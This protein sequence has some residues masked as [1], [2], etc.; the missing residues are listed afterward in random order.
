LKLE[1]NLEIKKK[2]YPIKRVVTQGGGTKKK[3]REK[4]GKG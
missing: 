3:K 2:P 1:T 4:L